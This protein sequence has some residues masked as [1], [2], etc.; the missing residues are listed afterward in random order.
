MMAQTNTQ[1]FYQR[2]FFFHEAQFIII[3]MSVFTKVYFDTIVMI[4]CRNSNYS[5]ILTQTNL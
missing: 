4:L 5:F 2:K 3:L 1:K